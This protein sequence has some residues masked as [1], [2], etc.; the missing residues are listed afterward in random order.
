MNT[1]FIKD[2]ACL[3]HDDLAYFW[4]SCM[5][6][7]RAFERPNVSTTSLPYRLFVSESSMLGLHAEL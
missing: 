5:K 3:V 4:I 6:Y 7:I 2:R 1:N